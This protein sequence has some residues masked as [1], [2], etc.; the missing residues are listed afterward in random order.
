MYHS[1]TKSIKK[2]IAILLIICMLATLFPSAAFASDDADIAETVVYNLGEAAITV[3]YDTAQAEAMPWEYQLFDENGDFTIELEENAFFP[4]E[5]QFTCEG[6]VDNVW[7][8]TPDSVVEIG[9]HRFSVHTEQTD[10]T[11]ISQLGFQIGNHYVAAYPE[12]KEFSTTSS[13]ISVLSL[14]PLEEVRLSVSLSNF[15]PP[16]LSKVKVS[17]LFSSVE[18]EE[19]AELL[20]AEAGTDDFQVIGKDDT[21][22]LTKY[23]YDTLEFIVGTADQLNPE[24]TRYI[25]AMTGSEHSEWLVPELYLQDD[26]NIRTALEIYNFSYYA[27]G[28]EGGKQLSVSVAPDLYADGTESYLGLSLNERYEDR[29]LEVA[30]YAGSFATAEEAQQAVQA[31]SEVDITDQIWNQTMT[32]QD[33][34]YKKDYSEYGNDDNVITIVLFEDGQAIGVDQIKLY[35][36]PTED[37]VQISDLYTESGTYVSGSWKSQTS[38]TGIKIITTTLRDNYSADAEYYLRLCYRYKGEYGYSSENIEKAVV[39]HYDNLTEASGQTDIKTELFDEDGYLANYCGDGVDFTVFAVDG[40]VYKL[41]IKAIKSES[42]PE[43]KPEEPTEPEVEPVEPL[44]NGDPYFQATS[45]TDISN[46]HVVDSDNDAYYSNGYQTLFTTTDIDVTT[47]QLQFKQAEGAHVYANGQL[48]VSGESVQNFVNGP[49]QYAVSAED[50]THL[51]NYWVTVEKQYVGGAKLFVNGANVKNE[52]GDVVREVFFNDLSGYDH[53]IFIANLGDEA[54]TGLKVELTD[55]QHVKL[56][57]YWTIG[58]TNTLSAFTTTVSDTSY[59]EL[60]NVA[61]LRLLPDGDG[62][63]SGTLTISADG[64]EPVVIKLIGVAGNPKITSTDIPEAVKYVP[65]GSVIQTN[66]MYDWN[67]VSFEVLDGAL[68]EG[69][70]IRPNGEIYGVPTETGEFKF[71]VRM[72]NSDKRF[73]SSKATFTLIVNENTDEN[74]DA[75]TDMGY[76]VTIRVPDKM[77]TVQ[78]EM[79]ETQGQ[80][81]DFVDFWLDGEKL[82][83]GVDYDAEEGSTKITVRAQTFRDAGTGK[84]T[85][86]AEFRA[87]KD[88]NQPLKRAAQNYE[89]AWNSSSGGSSSGGSSSGTVTKPE[90]KP[91]TKPET[92]NKPVQPQTIANFNDVLVDAWYAGEVKWV[93]DNGLMVG[94]SDHLFAPNAEISHATV[95]SVLAR[96]G[97][98]DVTPYLNNTYADIAEGEWY[99]SSAK[100]AKAT[101]LLGKSAFSANPPVARGELAQMLVRYF[102][103]Q[104]VALPVVET[105]VVFADASS[106]TPEENAAFQV[107]YQMQIFKG[108]GDNN[109]DAKGSTTR[110]ELA[111]L[112]HRVDT[113][114]KTN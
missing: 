28:Y 54:L 71:T 4:Y 56:D 103:Q 58:E 18:L 83:P 57:N 45:I 73:A 48:Q 3:G 92:Q 23:K 84:H 59:G 37:S 112:L 87:N 66:N 24:N 113:A 85:I 82:E 98:I 74:V 38:E 30:V 53:D 99:T 91:A 89:L 16:E 46:V 10:A 88:T 95:V 25:V 105:E 80:L 93:S 114:L 64:Q 102:E 100:W 6:E 14:Q 60:A 41:T 9:G 22:D 33:A 90:T 27:S 52:D 8:E 109:M 47:V 35:V 12:A 40:K 7:F 15:I 96:T 110:A 107:L 111:A 1:S 72:N 63:I 13:G 65:Y 50:G 44:R 49:V 104:Q 94:V 101:D 31:N 78:D 69:M 77:T 32:D 34:G 97:N 5:V 67:L 26:Q 36:Y 106:M 108:K 29:S 51:K 79:F 55:A 19:D 43:P 62:V 21:L 39:G 11:K 75:A 17:A 2:S 70:E 76:E 86:A 68:P 61:K 42:K 81:G 20:Y